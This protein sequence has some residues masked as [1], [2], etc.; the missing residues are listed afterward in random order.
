MDFMVIPITRLLIFI[1]KI[2]CHN[3]KDLK[4]TKS[5]T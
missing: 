2:F 4:I 1:D 5:T 3:N